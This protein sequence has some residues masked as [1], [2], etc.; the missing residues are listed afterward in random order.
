MISALLHRASTQL[1]ESEPL[2]WRV[3][4]ATLARCLEWVRPS[5]T[6]DPQL[7]L[8]LVVKGL[9][10]VVTKWP[11]ADDRARRQHAPPVPLD[12]LGVDREV[13]LQKPPV[14]GGEVN[15]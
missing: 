9:K 5:P 3:R 12:R 6:R 4:K 11:V 1:A 13:A 14:L 2:Q 15:R 10:V 7:V 8:D